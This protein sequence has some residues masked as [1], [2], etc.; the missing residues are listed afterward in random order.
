MEDTQ[1]RRLASTDACTDEHTC[2]HMHTSSHKQHKKQ[3][4]SPNLA[5]LIETNDCSVVA[6]L[7]EAGDNPATSAEVSP[8]SR[9]L[10]VPVH[11]IGFYSFYFRKLLARSFIDRTDSIELSEV[12]QMINK[13]EIPVQKEG[14]PGH[15]FSR[16]HT[17]FSFE[18]RKETCDPG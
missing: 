9:F 13:A 1:W 11:K 3:V 2:T 18:Q 10:Q 17:V 4:L 16:T 6:L 5:H 15:H 7:Q 8:Q 14:S 12:K